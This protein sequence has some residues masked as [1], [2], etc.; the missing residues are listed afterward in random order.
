M[1]AGRMPFDS[2]G[3]PRRMRIFR[4]PFSK[5][6]I[7]AFFTGG[8]VLGARA[9]RERYEQ[10][11]NA[12]NQVKEDPRVQQATTRAEDV[13]RETAT[14]VTEDPRI[15]EAAARAH[16]VV[17]DATVTVSGL[18][19]GD[20]PDANK[21]PATA[22]DIHTSALLADEHFESTDEVVYSSGPDIEETVD[23]LSPTNEKDRL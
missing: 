8:Y 10:I 23:E 22:G 1:G 19:G 13:V 11:V 20:K 21:R 9:G 2:M 18:V 16:D 4:K 5:L 15:K 14:K 3:E 7:L 17:R 12:A 6:T